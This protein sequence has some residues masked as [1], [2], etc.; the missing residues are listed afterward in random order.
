[1]P[2]LTRF[3]GRVLPANQRAVDVAR[4]EIQ[5][6]I[7]A[8]A[9]RTHNALA[10]GGYESIIYLRKTTG[11]HCACKR[12]SK[13]VHS[14]LD[15][16]GN[17]SPGLIETLITG[18][19]SGPVAYGTSYRNRD[20]YFD[21]DQSVEDLVDPFNRSGKSAIPDANRMTVDS[22]DNNSGTLLEDD[23]LEELVTGPVL[24]YGGTGLTDNS[25]PICFG[26]G[27]VGG[28]D[29]LSGYRSVLSYQ[30]PSCS[31]S[32]VID[33][34]A[35]VPTITCD[36]ITFTVLLP[37]AVAVDAFKVYSV[38]EIMRP[39]ITVDGNAVLGPKQLLPYC[40]GTEH[41]IELKW[42]SLVNFTHLEIQLQTADSIP[43]DFPKTTRQSLQTVID[44]Y[45][46]MQIQVSPFVPLLRPGDVVAESTLGRNF[47]VKNVSPHIDIRAHAL[48]WEADIRVIQP[49]E[50]TWLLPRRAKSP[51]TE[52]RSVQPMLPNPTSP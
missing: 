12:K 18:D 19:Q 17:L 25:C 1:M 40:D 41:T 38:R 2:I 15:Q 42:D 44:N 7:P 4:Q 46:D 11:Q 24:D 10:V 3:S 20:T 29:L 49:Q 51:N 27:F 50:L 8:H 30:H 35:F 14:R 45:G 47:M 16:D 22:Q 33:L 26:T 39:T 28:Y 23:G 32:G 48:G 6:L 37:P 9:Q 21:V 34:N 36:Q 43:I 13:E 52:Y 31:S 5:R